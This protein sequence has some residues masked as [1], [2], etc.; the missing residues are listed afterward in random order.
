MKKKLLSLAIAICMVVAMLPTMVLSAGAETVDAEYKIVYEFGSNSG[1]IMYTD[2]QTSTYTQTKGLW[3]GMAS[4]GNVGGYMWGNRARIDTTEANPWYALKIKV[5]VAN[6]YVVSFIKYGAN[7]GADYGVGNVYLIAADRYP[8]LTDENIASAISEANV[9][10]SDI[11][12]SVDNGTTAQ[13]T[14]YKDRPTL[15]LDAKEY[16]VIFKAT[17]TNKTG[18]KQFVTAL[19][20]STLNASNT[21]TALS[22]D[23]PVFT[24]TVSVN[25]PEIL[26]GS[27][28][29][30]VSASIYKVADGYNKAKSY[31]HSKTLV[32]DK[33]IITFESSNTSVAT[34]DSDGN[35]TAV[36]PGTTEITAKLTDGTCGSTIPATL[37][38]KAAE[39]DE[40]E[41]FTREFGEGTY[42]I[43]TNKAFTEN[44][45]ATVNVYTATLGGEKSDAKVESVNRGEIFTVEAD[46][47]TS[48]GL[49]FLY[50]V[51]GLSDKKQILTRDRTLEFI[52]TV[53]AS[54]VIAVYEPTSGATVSGENFYNANGQ[55]LT[56][57]G[58]KDNKMPSLPSMTGYGTASA[59]VQYGTNKEFAAG[60]NAPTENLMF[61]AKYGEPTTT[62]VIDVVDGSGA[63]DYTY[64]E[65]V[66]CT[67]TVPEDKVFKC[68]TKTPAGSTTAK[69]ISLDSTYT[70]NVWEAC[71]LT[72]VVV[73]KAPVFTG[74]KFSIIL[75][76]M[77]A[78]DGNTAYMAEFVGLGDAVEKGI[79]FGTKKVAMTTNAAQFT[80]VNDTIE[81]DI[82]GYAIL[83][84]GTVIYDK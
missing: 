54:H 52:P 81:T 58:I 60:E 9:V 34:V 46:D 45:Q 3:T 11:D 61:V 6:T 7:G 82:K 57:V 15:S 55:L 32:E 80:V 42:E 30:T 74:N 77:G 17:G 76:T 83:S 70:F 13:K 37:T 19:I 78:V 1:A 29:E 10:E 38:V 69:I 40:D 12:Y 75:S 44:T 39:P 51:K 28:I 50:W 5:P 63:G 64:G 14:A 56:N 67:A 48:E 24:G 71:T 73:D 22:S 18:Y 21:H 26:V 41:L 66:T 23:K 72:A 27:N 43:D 16:I 20:L 4:S 79:M 35:I 47:K 33:S 36:G 25:N 53:E 59:W 49:T 84:D 8:S 68:W 2:P 31:A 62:Y 65:E